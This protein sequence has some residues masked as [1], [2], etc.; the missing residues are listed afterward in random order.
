[1]RA[2]WITVAFGFV[3]VTGW[4]R[5]ALHEDAAG[6]VRIDTHVG[7]DSITVGERLAISYAA[8]YPESLTLIPPRE[9]DTGN[10]RLVSVAWRDASTAQAQVK[11]ADLVVL[12]VNLTSA[13][14]PR[15]SFLFVRPDGDTLVAYAN[16]IDVP[17]RSLTEPAS[18]A[19]PLKPQWRAPRNYWR[20]VVIGGLVL[21]AAALAFWLWRRLR[22]PKTVVEAPKPELPADYVALKALAE[23]EGMKLLE[24]GRY[25]EYYTRVVDVLRHYFERRFA[26]LAMDRTTDEILRDLFDR[27][28]PMNGGEGLLREADLVKFAKYRPD[29]VAGR[30]AMETARELVVRTTPRPLPTAGGE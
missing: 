19:R 27:Q 3:G 28:V 14:V 5:A 1:M 26:I 24:A 7:V 8:A 29:V 10:C 11:Q 18:E 21:V 17:I 12:P 2:V 16:E 9:F 30:T 20:Y 22:R 13:H 25:K 15:A 4:S 23:I 6:T